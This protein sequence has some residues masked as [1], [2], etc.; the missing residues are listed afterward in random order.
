[1]LTQLNIAGQLRIMTEHENNI[2]VNPSIDWRTFR[3]PRAN[4]SIMFHCPLIQN[5]WILRV[6]PRSG[7]PGGAIL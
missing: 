4:G 6:H 3:D 2:S 1:M 5:P 7:P